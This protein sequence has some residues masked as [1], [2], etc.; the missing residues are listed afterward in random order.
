MR[1]GVEYPHNEF[2]GDPRALREYANAVEDLGYDHLVMYDHPVGISADDR[3]VPIVYTEKDA[4]HDPLVAFSYLAGVTE[5]IE[6]VTGIL[7]LPQRQTV[8]VARQTADLDLMS[9][10]RLR[11]GVAPGYSPYEFEALGADF[12]TRGKRLDEQIT[13]LR[14]L[15]SEELISF[16]GRFDRIDRANIVP[17]PSRRIP[18]WCGGFSEPAY[19]RAVA[20]ADGF[21]FGYGMEPAARRSWDRIQELLAERRRPIAEFGAEFLLRPPEGRTYSDRELVDGLRELEAAGA[22][23]AAICP[24]GRGLGDL[25]AHVDYVTSLKRL[26]EREGL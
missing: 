10:G 8:L 7:V 13:Y 25:A 21:M 20:L 18:I 16:E 1:L 4:F 5:R 15:W 22:T 24:M 12:R 19:R 6:F 3:E 9:G 11:L 23:H 2:G 14:R 17:R 26:F